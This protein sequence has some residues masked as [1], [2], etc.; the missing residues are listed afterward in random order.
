MVVEAPA[1]LPLPS[2]YETYSSVVTDVVAAVAIYF[3]CLLCLPS[4]VGMVAGFVSTRGERAYTKT[5]ERN[6]PKSKTPATNITTTQSQEWSAI[7]A[8]GGIYS[9]STAMFLIVFCFIKSMRTVGWDLDIFVTVVESLSIGI[10]FSLRNVIGNFISG[11][12]F[13]SLGLYRAGAKIEWGSR[14]GDSPPSTI[15]D[16]QA[17]GLIVEDRSFKYDKQGNKTDELATEKVQVRFVPYS[18]LMQYGFQIL[19]DD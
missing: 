5:L 4:I 1:A 10:G 2:F 16:R 14:R 18:T 15:I 7:M 13:G 17:A 19:K 9:N 11:M 12:V 3:V 8:A 6:T